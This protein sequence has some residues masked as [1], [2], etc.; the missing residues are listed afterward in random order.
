LLL[1][2]DESFAAQDVLAKELSVFEELM[3]SDDYKRVVPDEY[4][5]LPILQ[6][7]AEV[8]MVIVKPDGSQFN[9]DGKLYDKVDLKMIIDGYNAPVTGGNF[10]DLVDVGFY[11]GKKVRVCL[12]WSYRIEEN[13]IVKP[14]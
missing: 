6:G 11:N 10:I 4:K 14:T 13:V 5:D 2:L 7:R 8:V 3:V 12:Y 1:G 9:I